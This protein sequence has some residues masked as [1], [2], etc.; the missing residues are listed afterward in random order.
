MLDE[1]ANTNNWNYLDLW[2]LV[3]IDEFTNSAVHLTPYGESLLTEKIAEAI[4]TNCE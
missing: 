3:P 1:M 4:Q 2:D